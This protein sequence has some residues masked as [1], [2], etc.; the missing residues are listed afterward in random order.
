MDF[1][2]RDGD[3]EGAVLALAQD[4]ERDLGARLA[5]H[6][7]DRLVQRQALHGGVVDAGDEVAGLDAGVRGRR[8]LDGRYDLHQPVLGGDFDADADEFAA[9]ALAEFLEAFLVEVFG[10]GVE[11]VNHAGNGIVNQLLALHGLEIVGLDQAVDCGEL[12]QFLQ[13][14]RR[15]GVARHGLQL[16]GCQSPGEHTDGD[17]SRDFEFASH[18]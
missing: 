11:A 5:A 18:A 12:L 7:L 3:V 16:Q 13:R 14:Q 1:L 9:G 10:M 2:A 6:E 4:G 17:P 8:A 15:H